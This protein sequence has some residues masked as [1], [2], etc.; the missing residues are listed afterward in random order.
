MKI[1]SDE[2]QG[3]N[4]IKTEIIQINN[5]MENKVKAGSLFKQQMIFFLLIAMAGN[6]HAQQIRAWPWKSNT[7]KQASILLFGDTNIQNRDHP[8]EAFQYVLPTLENADFVFSNLEGPFAG[9]SKDDRVPDIPHKSGW[10]H[11][12]PGMVSGLV[13]AGIDAVGVANNVTYPWQALMR[14]IDVLEAHNIKY[15]GGGENL[16]A[17]HQPV[18]FEKGG[19]KVG[20][21]AYACTVFPFQHAAEPNVPGIATVRVDTYFKPAKNLDK[22]GMPPEAITIPQ[23]KE[24]E[25]MKSDIRQLKE[26]VDV[27]ISSYHWGIADHTEL[28]DY[29]VDIAH[30]AIEAGADLIMGHGNHLLGAIEVWNKKPI[31]YGLGNFA[32]DWYKVHDFE[33][34]GVKVDIF[35]NAIDRVS[36][37]PLKGNSNNQPV[38]LDPSK[39]EGAMLVEKVHSLSNGLAAFQVV[40]S[41]V[42]I[43]LE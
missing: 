14:S 34:L 10:T 9:S 20:F 1:V 23:K 24:L 12:E 37:V 17:A 25:R 30:A 29:Q 11:S 36:F 35:G 21:L 40:G 43:D 18:I 4:Q 16:D 3:F 41:E 27:V 22:P 19:I 15:T 6:V 31:F 13:D 2:L 42:V 38:L 28:I 7:S 8:V 26:R 5:D 33:G 32:F 39:G